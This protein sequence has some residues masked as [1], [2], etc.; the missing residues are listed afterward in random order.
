VAEALTHD[1]TRC[2]EGN[3][4]MPA[5]AGMTGAAVAPVTMPEC[6]LAYIAR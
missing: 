5:C 1:F 2:D 4:W 3:S 6:R